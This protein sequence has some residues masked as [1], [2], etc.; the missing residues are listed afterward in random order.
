MNPPL[1]LLREAKPTRRTVLAGLV[2]T[3]CGFTP[4]YGPQG[5]AEGLHGA[6]AVD[7]PRDAEGF[8]YVRQLEGRL[9]VADA[10][11]YRL[12]SE[13]ALR[14]QELGIT[15]DQVITRYQLIGAAEFSLIDMATNKVAVAGSVNTFTSYSA[16]GTPVATRAAQTDAQ[17]RLMIALADLVVARILATSGDWS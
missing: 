15:S 12:T 14:E 7:P 4:V 6:I 13:L 10:P 1:R 2:L 9:G 3:G 5:S 11:R 16:T 17:D 8:V